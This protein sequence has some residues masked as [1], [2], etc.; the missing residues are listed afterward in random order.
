MRNPK[1][2][3]PQELWSILDYDSESGHFTW[4]VRPYSMFKTK[5]RCNWWNKRYAG[6]RALESA[7]TNGYLFGSIHKTKVL[8]HRVAWAMHTGSWPKNHIDH[9]NG[10][11]TDNRA[12]NL[13]DVPRSINQRNMRRLPAYKKRVP[14]VY[15]HKKNKKWIAR[16]GNGSG[17][18]L[19]LGSYNC[20]GMAIAARKKAERRLGYLAKW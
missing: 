19:M 12:V 9:I 15:F 20:I 14:G 1:D 4:K 6:K 5:E 18:P 10:D 2:I 16:I 11:R 8:S 17:K 7:C 3:D 13:R